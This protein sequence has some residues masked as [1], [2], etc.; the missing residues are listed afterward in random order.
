[1]KPSYS[2]WDIIWDKAIDGLFIFLGA[3]VALYLSQWQED[4]TKKKELNF[5]LSQILKSLPTEEV[6]TD[7]PTFKMKQSKDEDGECHFSQVILS[8]DNIGGE[9][10]LGVI[11]SRGLGNYFKKDQMYILSLMAYYYDDVLAKS[12]KAKNIFYDKLQAALMRLEKNGCANDREI[13][14]EE[15]AMADYYRNFKV[16]TLFAQGV[17]HKLAEELKSMGIKEPEVR[18]TIKFSYDFKFVDPEKARK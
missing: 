4:Q 12:I 6:E 18:K 8:S 7:I 16:T 11:Q 5:H 1:M 3:Y 14:Y 15:K 10:H 17:G 9:R 13:K 2:L